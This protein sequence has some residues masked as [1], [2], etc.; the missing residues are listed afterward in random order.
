MIGKRNIESDTRVEEVYL[1]SKKL[2]NL[3]VEVN[4]AEALLG[5]IDL[6]GTPTHLEVDF[7]SECNLRCTMCHQSKYDMGNFKLNQDQIDVIINRFPVLETV[8]IAGLG[9]PLLY[10]KIDG[11]LPFLSRYGCQSH[12]FTNG[13]LI[14]KRLNVLS[15]LDRISISFDGDNKKTFEALRVRSDFNKIITNIK[16]LR[17]LCP[18]MII[19]TSTVVSRKNVNEILG[20]VKHAADLGMNEVHLTP[21]DHTPELA[22]REKDY[23]IF[24]EQL[25][26]AEQL[27]KL[28]G[29]KVFNNVGLEHFSQKHNSVITHADQIKIS[30]TSTINVDSINSIKSGFIQTGKT[31]KT[32]LIHLLSFEEEMMEL[33]ER[34]VTLEKYLRSLKKEI[35]SQPD[36]LSIPSCTAPWK[37]SFARS[38][39]MARLCPYADI[40]VGGVEHVFS[41]SYNSLTLKEVRESLVGNAPALS[42]C[43][44]CQDD[45]RKFKKCSLESSLKELRSPK[46]Q[47]RYLARLRGRVSML[48]SRIVR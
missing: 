18:T 17:S 44:N 13:L 5:K 25:N 7:L 47:R 15:H 19:V 8:M 2:K 38:T 46:T 16:K 39:G 14:D 23:A 12:L 9:E 36:K 20:I 48:K 22:L 28:S 30:K 40:D 27:S 10:K 34:T 31:K 6:I 29:V 3:N 32:K 41:D 35:K 45:H 42:V 21:V 26:A 37:Y 4:N 33:E 1:L 11:I 24:L 43:T